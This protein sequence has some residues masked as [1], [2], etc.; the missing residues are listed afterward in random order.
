MPAQG[1]DPLE[2]SVRGSA[3]S[4]PRGRGA[5]G[6]DTQVPPR[7]PAPL[8]NRAGERVDARWRDLSL[9]TDHDTAT[10]AEP[11]PLA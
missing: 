4:A 3:P 8:M 9:S 7:R 5:E 11:N 6:G 2:P 10:P 1:G